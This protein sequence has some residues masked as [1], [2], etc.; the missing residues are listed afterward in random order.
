MVEFP[1]QGLRKTKGSLTLKVLA[2]G[3]LAIANS[4]RVQSVIAGAHPRVGNST[5]PRGLPAWDPGPRLTIRERRW[6]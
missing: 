6:R 4:F 3:A 5:T 1:T 2:N